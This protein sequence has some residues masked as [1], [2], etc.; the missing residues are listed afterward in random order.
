MTY[1]EFIQSKKPLAQLSGFKPTTPPHPSLK[2]HQADIALWMAA[3]GRRACFMS[4]GLGKTRTH[5]QVAVWICQKDPRKYL[6][7]APL[8]VRYVFMKEEGPA[9]GVEMTYC[10][11]DAEV[12]AAGVPVI[13]DGV[14]AADM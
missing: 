1:A 8:G 14:E 11:T 5:I 13:D 2:A 10:T 3:G 12:D 6:I 9:M 4:F 7:I